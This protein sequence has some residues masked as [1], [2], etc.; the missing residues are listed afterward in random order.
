MRPA[1]L[2]LP[3]PI[4]VSNRHNGSLHLGVI[5]LP[6][7]APTGPCKPSVAEL[8]LMRTLMRAHE[9]ALA[10]QAE[11]LDLE[12]LSRTYAAL[13]ARL[14]EVAGMR[15]HTVEL[16][17]AMLWPVLPLPVQFDSDSDDEEPKPPPKP[18]PECEEDND[19]GTA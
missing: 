19:L 1:C 4:P 5:Q 3:L 11:G 2:E 17:P 6:R 7:A 13:M 10:A 14:L 15:V 12:R 9:D 8:A 16:T 18:E